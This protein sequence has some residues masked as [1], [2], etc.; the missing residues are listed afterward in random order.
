[1]RSVAVWSYIQRLDIYQ[2]ADQQWVVISVD[3]IDAIVTISLQYNTLAS[4]TVILKINLRFHFFLAI[5]NQMI[6]IGLCRL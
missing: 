5:C 3:Q 6:L 1:M 2:S 4:F